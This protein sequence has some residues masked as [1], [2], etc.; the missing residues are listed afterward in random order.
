MRDDPDEPMNGTGQLT[1]H[2]TRQVGFPVH[3]KY[4][5]YTPFYGGERIT[6]RV[7]YEYFQ[8]N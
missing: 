6:R 5:P 2:L 1:E 3:G 8:D 4:E 7:N